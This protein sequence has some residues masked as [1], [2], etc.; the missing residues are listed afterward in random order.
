MRV[1]ITKLKNLAERQKK[2]VSNF[3]HLSVLYSL[4]LIIPL[5]LYPYLIK[6]L[7]KETYGLV[8]FAQ[9]IISYFVLLV[10]FGFNLSATREVSIHRD[11]KEK[12]DEIVSCVFI[13]MGILFVISL[14]IL[15]FL[16]FFIPHLFL[17]KTLLLITMFSCLNEIL[18]PVWYFQGTEKMKNWTQIT[19]ISRLI[20][21]VLILIFVKVES[22]Y[23]KVPLIQNIG[24]L[25]SGI[26]SIY[27]IFYKDRLTFSWQPWS[28][29]RKFTTNSIPIFFS[30]ISG[31]I[32]SNTN[33][34]LIGS[35]L[36][37][38][39]VSLY[40]LA[41]KFLLVLKIPQIIITQGV[42][43]K[44][45]I[46]KNISIVKKLFMI[47]FV[48]NILF[49]IGVFCFA[50]YVVV[51]FIGETM[52]S[53]T[54]I[55]KT[56]SVAILFSSVNSVLGTQVLIAF[57][58]IREYRKAIVLTYLSFFAQIGILWGIDSITLINLARSIV[59]I[60]LL[61]SLYML[62]FCRKLIYK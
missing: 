42:F 54:P 33:K 49:V 15:C 8:I 39:Q 9:S 20:F 5:L 26:F 46:E 1:K 35:F 6:V 57:G 38:A 12:L 21:L 3:T 40:D 17:H 45:S 61:T 47:S 7:G 31:N 23:L 19:L 24:Y 4:N 22:D 37:L 56:M 10:G 36:G 50:N 60:E 44:I 30:N 59:S 14:A 27:I 25:F 29:L 62:Y 16:I 48:F 32:I 52:I 18:F 51:Q 2:L 41:E 53:A 43:P 34:V 28:V 11:N 55:I 58:H 13:I